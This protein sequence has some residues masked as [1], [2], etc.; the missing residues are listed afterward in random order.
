[1]III[2][3]SKFVNAEFEAEV[4]PIPLCMLPIGNKKMLELQVAHFRQHFMDEKIVVTLPMHYQ[5]TINEQ[6]VINTLGVTIQRI[7]NTLNF[8][9]SILYV[10]NVEI[11]YPYE[12][13][14]ILQGDR[15]LNDVPLEADCIAIAN[16][17]RQSDWY[18][19]YHCTDNEPHW[20]GYFSFS[21]RTNLAKALALT[22][23]GFCEAITHYR[24]SITMHSVQPTDW[25]NCSHINSYFNARSSITTQR[26]FNALTIK[27]GV[28][29]K[30]SDHDVK[31]Q[32][33]IYWFSNLPP[34][35]KRFTPQFIDSGRLQDG[36]TTYCTCTAAILF[37]FGIIFLSWL[38]IIL[39]MPQ[40]KSILA[41][42]ILI[43]LRTHERIYIA[44]K[45]WDVCKLIKNQVKLICKHLSLIKT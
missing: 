27:S 21:S 22:T 35:L 1:M 19:S 28:V 41:T 25:F 2:H 18:D 29:T 12:Q 30:T 10:L 45:P 23:K 14:R 38:K 43:N 11:D 7:C 9:K 31:I 8:A 37:G 20:L 34:K 39:V 36:I 13:I 17:Y 26:S 4:G 24:D 32:A 15:L 44:K 42:S 3:S 6:M 33:E 16:Q 40:V 5:L